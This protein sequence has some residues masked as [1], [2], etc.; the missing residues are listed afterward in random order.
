MSWYSQAV[1]HP[2]RTLRFHQKT[3]RRW[4]RDKRNFDSP[5]PSRTQKSTRSQVPR[6]S[7]AY[8]IPQLYSWN[9]LLH[10]RSTLF[11]CDERLRHPSSVSGVPGSFSV[12]L[13][14]QLDCW[15][16]LPHL[17]STLFYDYGERQAWI[18]DHFLGQRG[19]MNWK[20]CTERNG[21]RGTFFSDNIM[22]SSS[23][24][25]S[26][27]LQSRG[28]DS[29]VPVAQSLSCQPNTLVN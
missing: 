17:R 23:K 7:S 9:A 21:R 20:L 3:R 28:F 18:S 10:L 1:R 29:P 24:T 26:F 15:D 11:G 8:L 4:A 5:S 16:A 12:H 19:W 6:S 13:I 25:L 22:E 2:H 14:P 27:S